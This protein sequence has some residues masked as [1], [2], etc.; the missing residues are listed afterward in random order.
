MLTLITYAA[1]QIFV[2]G[3]GDDAEEAA[4]VSLVKL[5]Q[6]ISELD[7]LSFSF[8]GKKITDKRREAIND[9]LARVLFYASALIHLNHL[10]PE[11]FELDDLTEFA[12][13]FPMDY[14]QDPLLCCNQ[15]MG[16]TTSLME[17]MFDYDDGDADD[18]EDPVVEESVKDATLDVS[19]AKDTPKLVSVGEDG[20]TMSLSSEDPDDQLQALYDMMSDSPEQLLASVIAGALLLSEKFDTD[21]GV[22]MFNAS[23][24]EGL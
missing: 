21:I 11:R 9:P 14:H 2:A 24:I 17:Q 15:M 8:R 4:T 23:L 3:L 22:V 19:G 7:R 18:D 16:H 5:K 6:A 20:E 10:D 1:E 13:S 12:E